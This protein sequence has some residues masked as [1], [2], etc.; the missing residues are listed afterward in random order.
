MRMREHDGI[1]VSRL[2]L[3]RHAIGAGNKMAALKQA[4]VHQHRGAAGLDVIS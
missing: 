4:E 2:E 3:R 1:Q